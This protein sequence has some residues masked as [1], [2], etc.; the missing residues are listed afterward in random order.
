[1]VV[2]DALH[3][4]PVNPSIIVCSARPLTPVPPSLAL[5]QP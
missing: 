4:E 3:E 1:L 5:G 2:F